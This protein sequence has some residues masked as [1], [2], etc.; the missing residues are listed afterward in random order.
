[1]TCPECNGT[2]DSGKPG[3]RCF[4]C[5][6]SGSLCD[7]CG[8]ACGEPGQDLCEQCAEIAEEERTEPEPKR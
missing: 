7:Q 4:F 6:G 5:N 2:G 8:E 1:M 3:L